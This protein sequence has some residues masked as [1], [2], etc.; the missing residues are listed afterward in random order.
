[1]LVCCGSEWFHEFT[2]G[3]MVDGDFMLA[4]STSEIP[5]SLLSAWHKLGERRK[6]PGTGGFNH[7]LYFTLLNILN[8][9]YLTYYRRY[10][11]GKNQMVL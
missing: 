1:M 11:C 2:I 5:S 6:I 9:H 3:F 8:K 4:S 10:F 7:F